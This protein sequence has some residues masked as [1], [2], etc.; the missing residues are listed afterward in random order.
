[1]K[2]YDFLA[3]IPVVR[4]YIVTTSET[5]T[6]ALLVAYFE[7]NILIYLAAFINSL[8]K[9]ANEEA[10]MRSRERHVRAPF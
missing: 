3:F 9:L 4:Y 1:M 2:T 10:L 8:I 5:R 7:T 6:G